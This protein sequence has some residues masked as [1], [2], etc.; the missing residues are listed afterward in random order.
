MDERMGFDLVQAY[1][2]LPLIGFHSAI[3]V[4]TR[5]GSPE[6]PRDDVAKPTTRVLWTSVKQLRKIRHF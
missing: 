3:D 6:E 4:A 2:F 1:Q 5:V